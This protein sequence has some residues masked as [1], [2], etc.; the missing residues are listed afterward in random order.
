MNTM[1]FQI[2]CQGLTL[3][4]TDVGLRIVTAHLLAKQLSH[5][6]ILKI[7]KYLNFCYFGLE[8][9]EWSRTAKVLVG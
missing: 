1:F 6:T 4:C 8:Y 9:L 3:V 2:A 7:I 5:I